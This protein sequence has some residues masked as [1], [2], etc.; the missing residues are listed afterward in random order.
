MFWFYKRFEHKWGA[1]F[2]GFCTNSLILFG[3][4]VISVLQDSKIKQGTGLF[5]SLG[6]MVF[7]FFLPITVCIN[8]F[9][10]ES[11]KRR[12]RTN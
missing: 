8:Y 1:L 12:F 4:T 11:I 10:L 2:C 5:D 7:L 9:V 6:I 3:A